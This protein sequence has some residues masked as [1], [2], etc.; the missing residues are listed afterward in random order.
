VAADAAREAIAMKAAPF[1]M[2]EAGLFQD[3]PRRLREAL[4]RLIGVEADDVIL[5]NSTSYGL[6]LLVRGVDWQPG[7]EVLVVEGDFPATVFPWLVLERLGV[8]VRRMTPATGMVTPA[9][10]ERELRP[11]TRVFCTTWVHSFR[12]HAIYVPPLSAACRANGTLFALNASQGMGARAF[13]A[14][15]SGVDLVT[16]CGFKYLCGPY[17]TGFSWIRP[18][19]RA[20]L[21]M[22]KGYWLANLTAEDLAGRFTAELRPDI[23]ARA[24]DVSGTANFFNAMT[25]TASVEYLV[26]QGIDRI[27][28]WDQALASRLV[29][30]LAAGGWTLVSPASGAARTTLTV[31]H[32]ASDDQTSRGVAALRDRGIFAAMRRGNIRISPHLYNTTDE[33][34]AALAALAEVAP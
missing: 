9:D 23:G 31:L 29:E 27:A 17:G 2:V 15:A 3:V 11:A 5:G 33:I 20:G 25:W 21:H 1:R 34:D 8:T 22:P 12:G 19:V 14:P 6:S 18:E 10:L 32:G 13:D 26:R 30:G 16:S 7:D 24:F 4:G 28:D